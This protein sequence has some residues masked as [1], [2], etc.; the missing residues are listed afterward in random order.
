M[1]MAN[2]H[3]RCPW[4]MLVASADGHCSWPV[5]MA[6]ANGQCCLTRAVPL[7]CAWQVDCKHASYTGIRL[8]LHG[9]YRLHRGV[10]EKGMS[11]PDYRL[12]SFLRPEEQT[13]PNHRFASFLTEQRSKHTLCLYP[14]ICSLRQHKTLSSQLSCPLCFVH[15]V[16]RKEPAPCGRAH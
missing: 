2:A 15:H 9:G 4:P 8:H 1:P 7:A 14:A 16:Q 13:A 6:N 10:R 12:A 5:L 11:E 3:G